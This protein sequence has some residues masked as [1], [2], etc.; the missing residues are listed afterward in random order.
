M[1]ARTREREVNGR[2]EILMEKGFSRVMSR[3]KT[4]LL[5][6]P[7]QRSCLGQN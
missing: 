1:K 4:P 2:W 7:F 3:G 6:C 5:F